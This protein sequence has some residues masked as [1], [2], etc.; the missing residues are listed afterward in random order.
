MS[1]VLNSYEPPQQHGT[2]ELRSI[3]DQ[4]V[5]DQ[6]YDKAYAQFEEG[7]WLTGCPEQNRRSME[8]HVSILLA[9]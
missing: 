6:N 2:Y 9:F 7:G 8:N 1:V 5:N 4:F 3:M